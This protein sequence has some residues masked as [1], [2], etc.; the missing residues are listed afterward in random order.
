M[1]GRQ[2]SQ[3]RSPPSTTPPQRWRKALEEQKS[4]L[5]KAMKDKESALQAEIKRLKAEL[6][7]S[8]EQ[9]AA[10]SRKNDKVA[11]V[12]AKEKELRK[13]AEQQF[14]A[15]IKS[16]EKDLSDRDAAHALESERLGGIIADLRRRIEELEGQPKQVVPDGSK[17]QMY[18]DLKS[19]NQKLA[20][21]LELEKVRRSGALHRMM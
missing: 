9:N 11:A 20:K 5:T 12:L 21:A 8:Y 18:V 19:K 16:L 2:V 4:K 3:P 10:L 7:N 6:E 17:F 14:N 13:N 1:Q 15:T